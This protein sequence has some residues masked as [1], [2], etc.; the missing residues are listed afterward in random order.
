MMKLSAARR[1]SES[2]AVGWCIEDPSNVA[3]SVRMPASPKTIS[4]SNVVVVS[5]V[6]IAPSL[7]HSLVSVLYQKR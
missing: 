1:V 6:P 4:H 7:R 5:T 2:D 3:V